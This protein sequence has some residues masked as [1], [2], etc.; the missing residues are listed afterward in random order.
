MGINFEGKKYIIKT[1]VYRYRWR[2]HPESNRGN[3]ICNPVRGHSA[4]VP[5]SVRRYKAGRAGRQWFFSNFTG[6]IVLTNAPAR[7]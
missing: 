7:Y 2:H 5:H 1:I 4:M 3:R 6:Y